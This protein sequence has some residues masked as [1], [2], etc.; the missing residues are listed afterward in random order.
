M[1]SKVLLNT[2][3]GTTKY[4]YNYMYIYVAKPLDTLAPARPP[5]SICCT[6]MLATIIGQCLCLSLCLSVSLSLCLCL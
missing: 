4:I 6:Y 2:F 3:I 5:P 1:Y